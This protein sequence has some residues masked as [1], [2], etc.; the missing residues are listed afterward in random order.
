[1]PTGICPR[2]HL[3][4]PIIF[5]MVLK[6]VKRKKLVVVKRNL[7]QEIERAGQ[8]SLDSIAARLAK[9]KIEHSPEKCTIIMVSKKLFHNK[10]YPW[11]QI[12]GKPLKR[13]EP[14][15]YL[16]VTFENSLSTSDTTDH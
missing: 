7:R 12:Q 2:S 9:L 4:S 14:C 1:M 8:K 6:M 11:L 5:N 15:K 13:L 10:C 3:Y 16:G